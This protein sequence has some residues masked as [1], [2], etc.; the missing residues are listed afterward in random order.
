MGHE[1]LSEL[2]QFSNARKLFA[3][4]RLTDFCKYLLTE[5]WQSDL[6]AF[7]FKY[8]WDIIHEG[9]RLTLNGPERRESVVSRDALGDFMQVTYRDDK[10][11]LIELVKCSIEK[12]SHKYTLKHQNEIRDWFQQEDS[13]VS[14][15]RYSDMLIWLFI[16]APWAISAIIIWATSIYYQ[17]LVTLPSLFYILV[18]PFVSYEYMNYLAYELRTLFSLAIVALVVSVASIYD[19]LLAYCYLLVPAIP[20]FAELVLYGVQNVGFFPESIKRV[21]IGKVEIHVS[22]FS[23]GSLALFEF[24]VLR[25]LLRS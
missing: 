22:L 9:G 6:I 19:P 8:S 1:S 18:G 2:M 10:K 3:I 25:L 23:F 13:S 4:L 20:F 5:E 16:G 24:A 11:R 17:S 14:I 15:S 21:R 12:A 7:D